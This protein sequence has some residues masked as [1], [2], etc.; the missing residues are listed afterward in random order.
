MYSVVTT[1]SANSKN[2]Y[3]ICQIKFSEPTTYMLLI[4]RDTLNYKKNV[5]IRCL[6]LPTHLQINAANSL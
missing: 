3:Y 2:F 1:I 6:D 4:L 5:I